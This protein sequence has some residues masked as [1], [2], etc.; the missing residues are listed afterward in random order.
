MPITSTA[1]PPQQIRRFPQEVGSVVYGSPPSS[2][3]SDDEETE[4]MGR[5]IQPIPRRRTPGKTLDWR[6]INGT[7]NPSVASEFGDYTTS[8]RMPRF[9][10]QTR[11]LSRHR[12]PSIPEQSSEVFVTTMDEDDQQMFIALFYWRRKVIETHFSAWKW[13]VFTLRRSAKQIHRYGVNTRLMEETT[14]TI[15]R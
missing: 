1:S 5:R 9:Q 7:R 10:R 13:V 6:K 15:V 11:G 4:F 3:S 14:Q 8:R 2:L 12:S